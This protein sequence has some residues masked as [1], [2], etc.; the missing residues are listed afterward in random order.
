[1]FTKKRLED[2]CG[3]AGF[4]PSRWVRGVF[5][6]PKARIMGLERE[7]EEQ[8]AGLAGECRGRFTITRS[9]ACEIS[10]AGTLGSIRRWRSGVWFAGVAVV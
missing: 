9:G 5:G 8:L 10:P 1:V 4:R 3:F 2:A 6:D 7:E